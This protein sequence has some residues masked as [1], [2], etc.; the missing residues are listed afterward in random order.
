MNKMLD[1]YLTVTNSTEN[2]REIDEQSFVGTL[3]F[4]D[5]MGRNSFITLCPKTHNYRIG[6]CRKDNKLVPTNGGT[7]DIPKTTLQ[8]VAALVK[9]S[10]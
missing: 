8:K 4:T 5:S 2:A 10:K 1:A 9:A 6:G 7:F 3:Y